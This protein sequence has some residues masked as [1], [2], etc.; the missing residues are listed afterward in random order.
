MGQNFDDEFLSRMQ[1]SE[2]DKK[3]G[4]RVLKEHSKRDKISKTYKGSILVLLLIGGIYLGRAVETEFTEEE[5]GYEL[6]SHITG[7]DLSIFDED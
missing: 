2:W 4:E 3:I 1:D 5:T 7:T 6:L